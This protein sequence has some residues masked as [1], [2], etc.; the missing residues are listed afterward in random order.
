MSSASA[1][2]YRAALIASAACLFLAAGCATG[3][4]TLGGREKCWPESDRRAPSVWRGI[5]EIDASGGRLRTPEGDVIPLLLPGPLQ[6]VVGETGVG[7][8]V[9][10]LDVVAKAGDDVTLFGGAG[11]DGALV[12]CGVEEKHSG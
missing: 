8:L 2:H 7:E 6:T 1:A 10:D 5:L 11:A 3:S 9:R 4:G 12:V